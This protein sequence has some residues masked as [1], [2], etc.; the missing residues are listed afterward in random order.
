MLNW[1]DLTKRASGILSFIVLDKLLRLNVLFS[2]T[3][4]E[5]SYTSQALYL[6]KFSPFLSTSVFLWQVFK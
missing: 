4:M 2:A 5:I 3:K 6:F 1:S